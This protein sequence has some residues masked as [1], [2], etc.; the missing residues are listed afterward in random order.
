MSEALTFLLRFL[1]VFGIY[2]LGWVFGRRYGR[3]YP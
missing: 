1:A 3:R 2:W